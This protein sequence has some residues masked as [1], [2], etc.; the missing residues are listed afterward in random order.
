M[1]V[2]ENTGMTLRYRAMLYK[3]VV[4]TVLLYGVDSWGITRKIMKVLEVVCYCISR[5]LT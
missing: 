3:A 4:Q 2:L 5:R 1:R